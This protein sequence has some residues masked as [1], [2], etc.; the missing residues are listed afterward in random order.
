VKSFSIV[1]V[2]SP[3]GPSSSTSLLS[4]KRSTFT[5]AFLDPNML[6]TF[7]IAFFNSRTLLGTSYAIAPCLVSLL[8]VDFGFDVVQD[9]ILC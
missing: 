9:F 2:P 5:I 3:N 1:D 7:A 8:V 6:S 4:P